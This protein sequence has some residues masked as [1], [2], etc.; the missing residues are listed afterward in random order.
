MPI[1]SVS[2]LYS[3]YED[4]AKEMSPTKVDIYPVVMRIDGELKNGGGAQLIWTLHEIRT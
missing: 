4:T 2:D 1:Y 3:V